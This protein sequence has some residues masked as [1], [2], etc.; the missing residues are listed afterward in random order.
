MDFINKKQIFIDKSYPNKYFL[1]YPLL[2]G[3]SQV[4][5]VIK[6]LP[7]STADVRDT[8]SIPGLGRSPRGGHDN[9]L[10]HSC[11]KNPMDKEP[12]ELRSI[13]SQRVGHD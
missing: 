3:V 6:N 9:P 5:L 11:L 13:G 12:G 4:V 1:K 7:A 10:Q 2:S 8:G